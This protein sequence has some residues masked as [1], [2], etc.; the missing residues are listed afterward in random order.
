MIEQPSPSPTLLS[1]S[2]L[3]QIPI[4]PRAVQ[5][6][7]AGLPL[8][9]RSDVTSEPPADTEL[10]LLCDLR[11]QPVATALWVASGP[12]AARM[13]SMQGEGFGEVTL[14]RRLA[15]ALERR[16]PLLTSGERD[17]FRVV[18]GEADLLPGLFVDYYADAV[19]IQT[20]TRAMDRRKPLLSDLLAQL[21]PIDRVVVR[22]DGSARD[23]E[24]LPREKG[25]LRGGPLRRARFHDAGSTMEADL[26]SD[27][28][29]GSFLDQQDNHAEV[30]SWAQSLCPGG[31]ALDT[32]TYHGG[33]ALAMARAGLG[34]I[35]CDEDPLAI[36]RARHNAELS[37][38]AVDFHIHN[39]FDLL[40]S[41]EAEGRRFDVV[42]LDPPALAKRGR[43]A[44]L[45]QHAM[46][47]AMRAYK[48]L[49][50]RAL[51]ILRPG[52]LLATCSCSGRVSV[53]DFATMLRSAAQDAGRPLQLLWRRGAGID[54]P[55]LWGLPESEYLKCWLFRVLA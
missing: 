48:E 45:G 11:G 55:V 14:A 24:S 35:A 54:H 10:V 47:Q 22:D 9:L 31:Q 7:K 37:G 27:R 17:A 16:R 13:W 41:Y 20:A 12:L 6:L 15:A 26:L 40:R 34:V 50:L 52:G 1:P 49:N 4:V 21:L 38:V 28:K 43:T 18:H 53:E 25:F 46:T 44:A 33:F 36:A 23:M 3:C 19:V 30:A 42:V 32:F 8:V 29:T 39:A 51:R 2:G 5:R